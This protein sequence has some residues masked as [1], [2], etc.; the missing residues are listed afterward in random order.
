M[1]CWGLDELDSCAVAQKIILLFLLIFCIIY[2]PLA[3][4]VTR[5][6]TASDNR[7][8]SGDKA[9]AFFNIP[10]SD[11][12]LQA[13]SWK[14]V[15]VDGFE[16]L[17]EVSDLGRVR[18]SSDSCYRGAWKSGRF[19]KPS[20]NSEYGHQRVSL[21]NENKRVSLYLH[22]LVLSAFVGC[23]PFDNYECAHIDGNSMN[24]RLLNLRWESSSENTEDT[25]KHGT[26]VV[27]S[28]HRF[29]KLKEEYIPYIFGMYK[30]GLTQKQIGEIYGVHSVTIKRILQHRTWKH[31]ELANS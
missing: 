22:R 16:G 29:A 9:M 14:P 1:S 23:A 25:R 13:E 2:A 5:L 4:L 12:E 28:R 17:Y 24:N 7:I 18:R 19:L 27:G 15:S 30:K 26:M 31:V 21:Y 8:Y 6:T 10:F 11:E 20:R 3:V